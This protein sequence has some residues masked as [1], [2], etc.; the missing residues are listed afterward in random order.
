MS[1]FYIDKNNISNNKVLICRDESKH[2]MKVLRYK[3]EDLITL[4]DS[5]GMTYECVIK[6]Y[7]NEEIIAELINK[8]ENKNLE[9]SKILLAQAVLKSKK[10]D[11]VIQKSTE[12]GISR[13]IPFFSSRTIPRWNTARCFKKAEH[14][15]NI[16]KA[17]VKQSGIRKIPC[18]DNIVPFDEVVSSDLNM[19]KLLLYEKERNV[20]LKNIMDTIVFP[21]DIL[22]MVGAEGGFTSEEVSKAKQ[23]G[24]LTIG[25]GNLI[26]RAETVPISVLSILQYESGNL[27][28]NGCRL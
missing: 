15:R 20:S 14:W 22:I 27:G 24:F 8:I 4:F 2:I 17:S 11:S 21:S 7:E 28:F 16:V 19:N 13:I 10:M 3:I 9:S 18:V 23:S 12:L 5:D 6:A 25:I 1:K 26:L